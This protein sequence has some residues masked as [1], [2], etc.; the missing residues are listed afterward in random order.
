MSKSRRSL[1]GLNQ[2]ASA[3][4]AA[5]VAAALVIACSSQGDPTAPTRVNPA[6]QAQPGSGIAEGDTAHDHHSASDADKGYIDGW[7]DGETVQLY[8]TKWVFCAEPPS[9]GATDTSGENS[10]CEVGADGEVPP[11]PGVIPTIYAIAAVSGIHLNPA[12]APTLACPAGSTCLNHPAM[13][14]VSRIRGPGFENSPALPHSHILGER[15]GGWFNTVN[16]RVS[17]AGVWSQIAAA[18]TLAKVR[19]LQADPN[20]GG[21]GLI[22][23]DTPTN[24]YFFI[25]SWR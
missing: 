16:I 2:V 4:A 22:S 25:A 8:Y 15:R 1:L 19:E 7:S 21:R 10:G 5:T 18:R 11:R 20:V 13:L 3:A 17:D 9:S 14:D 23:Q 24:I 12:V 6:G